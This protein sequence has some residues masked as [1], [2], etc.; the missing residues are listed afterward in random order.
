MPLANPGPWE[1][2][3]PDRHA[4]IVRAGGEKKHSILL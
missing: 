2:G 4:L 3:I 1:F